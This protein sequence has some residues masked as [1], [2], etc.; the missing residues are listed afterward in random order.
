[1]KNIGIIGLWHQGIVGAACMAKIGYEVIAYDGN[2]ERIAILNQGKSTIY[3]PGLDDLLS[4]ALNE[5]RLT[6]TDDVAKVVNGRRDIMIMYDT[7]VDEDDN[8]DLGEIMATVKA[9]AKDLNND[10]LLYFTAQMPVG[11]CDAIKE[12]IIR[13]NHEAR[14]CIA[15]SPE[16]LRL[17]QAVDRFLHPALPVVGVEDESTYQR[18]CDL[19]A[20]LSVEWKKVNLRTAEMIKHALNAYI[21]LTICFGNEMGSICDEVG[22]DGHKIAEMLKLEE[23]IGKKA[24]LSPGLG[25]SGGTIARDIQT[26]R[27]LGDSYELDT[28]LLDGVWEANKRQNEAVLRILKKI[29]KNLH[30]IKMGVLGLTYKADT[31]TLRRSLSM[32]IVQALICNGAHVKTHDPKADR[33]ELSFYK[34]INFN[35]DPYQAVQGSN[36]LLLL[37]A[38]NEYKHLDYARIKENMDNN[39]IILDTAKLLPE[40]ELVKLGF[41]YISIGSGKIGGSRRC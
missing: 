32:E 23:R 25:F 17:G 31:S 4:S 24:M 35:E 38:W 13:E 30:G 11:T 28:I 26:L 7:P 34:N 29:Y 21:G 6:F 12:T 37:T 18:V 39:P 27:N 3:E 15:Y 22:A 40:D 9:I 19:L 16:N 36:V 14:F 8:L 20:P 41:H 1:M 5:K 33:R 2:R 10:H